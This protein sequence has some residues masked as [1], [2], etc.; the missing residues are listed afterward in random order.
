[1]QRSGRQFQQSFQAEAVITSSLSESTGHQ[2][3]SWPNI[4][5]E[6]Q[7]G[8][9]S[10]FLPFSGSLES[11]ESSE[12]SESLERPLP[13][14]EK[15]FAKPFSFYSHNTYQYARRGWHKPTLLVILGSFAL[16]LLLVVSLW[17]ST[18][19]SPDVTLF[20]VQRQSVIQTV[21]GGGTLYP[22]QQLTVSYPI[23]ERVLGV[24]VH[25]GDSVSSNQPLLR[26]D[27]TQ[28]SAQLQQATDNITAAQAYLSTVSISGNALAIAQAQQQLTLAR[29]RYTAL[30]S[31]LSYPLLH[32]GL[33]LSPLQGVV[34]AISVNAGEVLTA[35]AALLLIMDESA[36]IVH[37]QVPLANVGQVHP[38]QKAQ[39]I[40]SALSNR[41]FSGTVNT[42]IPQ[43]NPQTDTFEVWV[44]VDD[45]QHLLLPGMS[46]FVSILI[47]T[48]A[49]IVPRLSIMPLE[50]L[51]T[52]FVVRDQHA[53]LRAVQVS[54]RYEDHLFVS[55]GLKQGDVVVLVGQDQ[56]RD[57]QSV[58]IRS[59]E[60]SGGTL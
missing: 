14:L 45:P 31:Q 24:L 35:N 36:L 19:T 49:L 47:P 55:S 56:L 53:Y 27:T 10:A 17:L 13:A 12:P 7:I 26:L 23:R 18:R 11:L 60:R 8:T 15:Q 46:T 9:F 5:V 1:M 2:R 32:D 39:I 38:G 48:V 21:G 28:S 51:A 44:T 50:Q 29:N 34:T 4:E 25:V 54:G 52:V 37:M 41:T 57:G 3:Q 6:Q 16:L 40:P 30:S 59:V 20:Q 43:A 58:A 42:V 33:L 22:R